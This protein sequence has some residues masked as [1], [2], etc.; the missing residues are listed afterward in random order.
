LPALFSKLDGLTLFLAPLLPAPRDEVAAVADDHRVAAQDLGQL[1]KIRARNLMERAG[2]PVLPGTQEPVIR[3]TED[4]FPEVLDQI[5]E[6][7][8]NMNPSCGR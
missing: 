4:E 5:A 8:D 3:T 2:M 6:H 7:V 1:A